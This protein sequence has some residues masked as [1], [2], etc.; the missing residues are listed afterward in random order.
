MRFFKK[1]AIIFAFALVF[2]QIANTNIFV[3]AD[4]TEL[5]VGGFTSGFTI[6][7][8]GAY[9]IG[10]SDVVTDDYIDSPAKN[11]DI[12]VGDI[13]L[14]IDGKKVDGAMGIAS[15]LSSSD[16]SPIEITVKRGDMTLKKFITPK[17]DKSGAYKLGVLIK[18]DL[19][20]IG[21]ITYFTKD[22][23]FGALGHPV[24]DDK[25]EIF[26]INGGTAYL[27][28]VI[29]VNKGEK[30]KPGE[31]KGIFIE[32]TIIG[33]ILYN[34]PSGIYGKA[35]KSFDYKKYPLMSVGTPTAG[36]A[37]VLT[38]V[39]GVNAVEYSIDIVKT[40]LNNKENKNLVISVTDKKLLS[41]TNGILQGM[42]GSPIIQGG[43]IVGAV[44]HVFINDPTK[45]YGI[46]ID[47][48]LI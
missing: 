31:L 7:P 2:T 17:K 9:V 22:G 34:R 35:D 38:C 12:T 42:S 47:N 33:E 11:A 36:K 25:N 8:Q 23:N 5:Y 45:G 41:I 15:A 26:E 32:D 14:D 48:M 21:T 46:S 29:G 4:E 6:R 39:D 44:T 37:S 1:I 30:G 16:G 18:D 20:G 40:D 24:L 19:S 28:S 43:K 10:L 3:Y 13:I 27:C